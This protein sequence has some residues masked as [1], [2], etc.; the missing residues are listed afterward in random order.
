MISIF[1]HLLALAYG[2]VNLA[3]SL[4][5][6]PLTFTAVWVLLTMSVILH[7]LPSYVDNCSQTYTIPGFSATQTRFHWLA[8]S[9]IILL[10]AVAN[11][12]Q[13][14]V[15]ELVAYLPQ[16]LPMLSSLIIY[17]AISIPVYH[18]FFRLF[19][20][21]LDEKQNS[22]D[23]FRARMTIPILFFPPILTWMLIE[24]LTAGGL[25]QISEIKM[26][27]VAP[28][29]FVILYLFAPKLFNWAWRAEKS[30]DPELEKTIMEISIKAQSPVSGVKI[31]DTFNEPVPNAAVAGLSPRYRFVYITRYLL[32]LF[33]PAQIRGVV[34]H[35]L[36]HLRLG[37]VASYMV[38]SINLVLISVAYKLYLIAYLPEFY[39][40]SNL[41]TLIEML[42]FLGIFALSFTALARYSEYQ[43]DAFA[44]EITEPE[45][46][47][48]GLE[49]LNNMVMP[50][51]A[52]IP[53]WLLTHPQIHD[54]ICRV[55]NRVKTGVD[56]LVNRAAIIRK[57]MMALGLVML[58][59]ATVP[60][61]AVFK[62]SDLHDAVQAGNIKLA[63]SRYESLPERL[64]SHPLVIQ[65]TGKLA[66]TM[67]NWTLAMN[68]AGKAT[69]GMVLVPGLEILH[70]SG[71]PEVAFDLKVM[72][73]VL[74]TLDLR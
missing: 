50:P 17:L 47:A 29:F 70:H 55:R 61:Q 15:P 21:I 7:W 23:F 64:K 73:L 6:M 14:A 43:A 52:I 24:D 51:P 9:W 31:W 49:T 19:R 4:T 72:K 25:A 69:W 62:I 20:P 65:E 40:D 3:G 67:G 46:L 42:V 38:Y 44:A 18:D 33:T 28:F 36:G 11:P 57:T 71:S 45:S 26:M 54:R 22:K 37:H 32:E 12:L 59:A 34:A 27:I 58:L 10:Q 35:E 60:G 5:F 74:K 41:A 1:L 13:L 68:I 48:S 66:A 2:T 56:N 63:L 8:V 16:T 53:P 30:Q 39:A